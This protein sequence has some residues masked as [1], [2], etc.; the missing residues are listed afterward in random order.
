MN[1]PAAAKQGFKQETQL[2]HSKQNSNEF[3]TMHARI[4][5]SSQEPA[6]SKASAKRYTSRLAQ[7]VRQIASEVNNGNLTSRRRTEQYEQKETSK[8]AGRKYLADTEQPSQGNI[9][10]EAQR[11]KTREILQDFMSRVKP[12]GTQKTYLRSLYLMSSHMGHTKKFG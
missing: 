11:A 4:I 6:D 10:T 7:E 3:S 2:G 1:A 5:F 9:F 8:C 12:Y